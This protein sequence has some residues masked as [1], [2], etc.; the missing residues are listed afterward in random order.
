M[1]EQENLEAAFKLL[2]MCK[3]ELKGVS[4]ERALIPLIDE[5]LLANNHVQLLSGLRGLP[6][7]SP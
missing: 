3:V 2:E 6:E 1:N 7:V 4:D 5:Y